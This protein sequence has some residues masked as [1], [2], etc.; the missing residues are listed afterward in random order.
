MDVVYFS[1]TQ[2][3]TT[4]DLLSIVSAGNDFAIVGG[5]M[6]LTSNQGSKNPVIW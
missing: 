5:Q 3:R 6:Q 1:F 4:I 2:K